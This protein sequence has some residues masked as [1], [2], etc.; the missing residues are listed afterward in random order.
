M[1]AKAKNMF[2][3]INWT[4]GSQIHVSVYRDGLFSASSK[5]ELIAIMKKVNFPTYVWNFIQARFS[6]FPEWIMSQGE[7]EQLVLVD[8]WRHMNGKGD[9][10]SSKKLLNPMSGNTFHRIALG[11]GLVIGIRFWAPKGW[12]YTGGMGSDDEETDDEEEFTGE[13]VVNEED[14][15]EKPTKEPVVSHNI[16]F[17]IR[18]E[19][20]SEDDEETRDRTRRL[21]K[22]IEEQLDELEEII[23][24]VAEP[25]KAK[26]QKAE[27][28][29]EK[30]FV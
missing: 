17:R 7:F 20:Q 18:I 23:H 11:N 1:L 2:P 10:D 8:V 19:E 30:N 16:G 3:D 9:M 14:H 6:A 29:T 25:P 13:D 24:E 12:D 28:L 5:S 26:L 22:Q 4:G 21:V 15:E 27:A